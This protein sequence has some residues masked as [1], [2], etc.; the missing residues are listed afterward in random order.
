MVNKMKKYLV[1]YNYNYKS[2]SFH[3]YA[4]DFEDAR[5]RLDVIQNWSTIDG[6]IGCSI[7]VPFNS[8]ILAKIMKPII[9]FICLFFK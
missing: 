9:N 1:S 6:E 3:I 8:I 5:K 4:S 2:W 7:H